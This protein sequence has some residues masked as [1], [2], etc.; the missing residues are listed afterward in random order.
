MPL[1]TK[2]KGGNVFSITISRLLLMALL[3]STQFRALGTAVTQQKNGPLQSNSAPNNPQARSG[4][5][6]MLTDTEGIDFNAYIH[7]LYK[8]VKKSWF[9]NMAPSVQLGQQGKNA[10]QFRVLRDGTV[11]EDYLKL[12]YSSEK[13]D[14]DEASLQAVRKAAPFSRLPEKYSQPFIE[15]RMTFSYNVAP[16][17][18]Q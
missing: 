17:K 5:I 3:V 9:A 4:T 6:E 11:P 7:S 12:V 8:S 1:V 18:P 14:L 15:L 2:S 16:P 10:V 13:K